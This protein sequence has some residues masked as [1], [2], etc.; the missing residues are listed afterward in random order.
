[1]P[2][3]AKEYPVGTVQQVEAFLIERGGLG[4]YVCDW[5]YEGIGATVAGPYRH[6]RDAANKAIDLSYPV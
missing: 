5:D 3:R 6:R 4:W 1:M 2:R